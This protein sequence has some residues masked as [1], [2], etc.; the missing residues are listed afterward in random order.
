MEIK[1]F[2]VLAFVGACAT[3]F[4]MF[5]ISYG[6]VSL[7]TLASAGAPLVSAL[8]GWLLLDEKLNTNQKIG[9]GLILVGLILVSQL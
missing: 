1:K 8:Y 3:F 2:F 7:V 5:G 6:S 9:I 4:Y